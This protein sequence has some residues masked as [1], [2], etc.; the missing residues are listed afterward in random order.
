[1]PSPAETPAPNETSSRVAPAVNRRSSPEERFSPIE[2]SSS[3]PS[4]RVGMRL[5]PDTAVTTSMLVVP[6]SSSV[7]A[8]PAPSTLSNGNVLV[9]MSAPFLAISN[10]LT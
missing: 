7:A 9:G 6:E 1:M 5:R 3:T 10:K 4:G 2:P 8:E